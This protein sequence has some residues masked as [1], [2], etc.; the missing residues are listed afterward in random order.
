MAVGLVP[1]IYFGS[2][3]LALPRSFTTGVDS[4]GPTRKASPITGTERV[5]VPFGKEQDAAARSKIF[6]AQI[7]YENFAD[8]SSIATRAVMYAREARRTHEDKTAHLRRRW[9]VAN[10]MY[11]GNSVA[12]VWGLEDVHVPEIY[13]AVETLVPRLEEA[14]M[15]YDPYFAVRGRDAMDRMTQ[16]KIQAWIEFLADQSGLRRTIQPSIRS[17]LIYQFAMYKIWWALE[18]DWRVVK[19]VI[20]HYNQTGVD[21]EIRR[22]YKEVVTYD[23]PKVRL[24]D[25]FDAI[26]DTTKGEIKDMLYCGD[27]SYMTYGEIMQMGAKMGWKNLDQL[28]D[29]RPSMGMNTTSDYDKYSRSMT[30]RFAQGRK[31]PTGSPEIFRVTNIWGKYKFFEKGMR[32]ALDARANSETECTITVIEDSLCVDA[33]ENFFDNKHRPYA[34]ARCAKEAWDFY[35]VGPLD[36]GLRLNEEFDQHRT[37]L[38]EGAK[39]SQSPLIFAED[40]SDL[41]DTLFGVRP[42]T[43]FRS[44]GDVKFGAIPNTQDIYPLLDGVLRRDIEEVTGAQRIFE[45]SGGG[46]TQTATEIERKIQEG[47]RRNRGM[48]SSISLCQADVLKQFFLLSKQFVTAHQTFR[49]LGK[50]GK[51]VLGELGNITPVDL[52]NDVDFE[53]VGPSSLHTVGLRASALVQF[54]NITEKMAQENPGMRNDAEL[55]KE[56]YELTVGHRPGD[57]IIRTQTMPQDLMTPEE[58]SLLFAQGQSVAVDDMDDD[59]KHIQVHVEQLTRGNLAGQGESNLAE[60]ILQHFVMLE[61]KEQEKKIMEQKQEQMA[62]Q[63]P[64]MKSPEQGQLPGQMTGQN[65]GPPDAQKMGKP[66]RSTPMMQT[67]DD[68]A[69]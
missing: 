27:T 40:D 61:K 24:V 60:H 17:M 23:G 1:Q 55:M 34:V 64:R 2:D 22:E 11:R 63:D 68:I 6:N 45:G 48:V 50:N 53:I 69:A 62:A 32:P 65:P 9:R 31:P 33:R 30:E 8:M 19:T 28:K 59:E 12:N 46:E 29:V 10:H 58:E 25:P 13:K 35:N 42:G 7:A 16:A 26:V 41:P 67:Q 51:K 66:G 57:Q 36:H 56:L 37:L 15:N 47:N 5:T 3:G 38:L 21:Y 44:V 54:M 49:V 43:V 39:L 18:T 20:P 4:D 14:V 52:N